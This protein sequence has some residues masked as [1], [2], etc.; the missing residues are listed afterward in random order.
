MLIWT[1]RCPLTLSHP[2]TNLVRVW[3]W[4][5]RRS[6]PCV[7]LVVA[8][9]A[10]DGRDRLLSFLHSDH[11]KFT[12]NTALV[13]W[14]NFGIYF[15]FLFLVWGPHLAHSGLTPGGA[16]GTVCGARA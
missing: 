13:Y 4:A 2:Q 10:T 3:Q 5:L 12:S 1:P 9:T 14:G 6:H 15:L 8:R 16:L 7:T 11:L